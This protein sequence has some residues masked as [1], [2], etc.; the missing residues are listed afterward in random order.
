MEVLTARGDLDVGEG[1]GRKS[2]A[3]R[4]GFRGD[5]NSITGKNNEYTEHLDG[6]R[7]NY[8]GIPGSD[9]PEAAD[10]EV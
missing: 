4:L 9:W 5:T 7:M 10:E 1:T 2:W 6:K 3:R 8:K